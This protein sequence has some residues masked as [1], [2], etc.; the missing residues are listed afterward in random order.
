MKRAKTDAEMSLAADEFLW[1]SPGLTEAHEWI[2]PMVTQWLD[3]E[4]ARHVFDLG[5][6]NGAFTNIIA[7]PN[8]ELVGI[9]V[10][11]SGIDIARRSGGRAQFLQGSIH[12]PLPEE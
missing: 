10:S 4:N 9:D 5:C 1:E 7:R 8:R 11:Q 2:L 3:A 12:S 6:G